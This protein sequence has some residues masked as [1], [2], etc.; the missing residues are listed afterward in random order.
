MIRYELLPR[1]LIY[2]GT[3]SAQNFFSPDVTSDQNVLRAHDEVYLNKRK[4]NEHSPKAVR[5]IGFPWSSE[6]VERELRIAQGT[7][8]GSLIALESGI[9][10]NIAGGTHHAYSDR[11]EAFCML[12]D[13]AIA[14]H[15]LLDKGHAKKILIL[16]L[17]VHQGNGTAQI[18]Q[19]NPQVFT[20]SMHCAVNFPGRKQISDLDIPLDEGTEDDEYLAKLAAH[21][22]GLII[23]V[24][25]HLVF[26]DAGVDPHRDDRLG[27]LALTDEGLYRRDHY[28]LKTCA[29][30][31]YPVAC[32]IGGGYGK[33]MNALI[34]RHSY[35]HRPAREVYR[36]YC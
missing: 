36:Q 2:E 9:A 26:Y 29:Q 16:D 21:L 23:Q 17:D 25:P 10:M 1:Q 14:A 33:D 28:V 18:F 8:E 22:P 6:L 7:I 5:K 11:G 30:A 20:F 27:K 34:Y 4:N 24:K 35:L 19:D 32:V 12:N 13:Q 31:G 3:C 15:Y